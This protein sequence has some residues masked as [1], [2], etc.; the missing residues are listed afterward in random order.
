MRG[1]SNLSVLHAVLIVSLSVSKCSLL[2]CPP[3]AL[4][5]C[6][7]GNPL[8]SWQMLSRALRAKVKGNE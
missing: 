5:I 3:C 1:Y 6:A 7:A 8:G 4:S 2:F